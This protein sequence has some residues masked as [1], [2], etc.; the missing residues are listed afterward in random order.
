M[1]RLV[2]NL[3]IRRPRAVI[4]AWLGLIAGLHCLAPPWNRITK[5][6]DLGLFPADSPSMIAQDAAGARLSPR[7]PRAP[8]S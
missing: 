6:D 5:D 7:M 2:S 4:L 1:F 8:S 3:V